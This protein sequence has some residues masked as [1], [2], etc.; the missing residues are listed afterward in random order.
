MF[1]LRLSVIVSS[2]ERLIEMVSLTF[3]RQTVSTLVCVCVFALI[4]AAPIV[5]KQTQ[6][7]KY[8]TQ[9]LPLG[10]EARTHTSKLQ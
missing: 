3:M 2:T 4:A 1:P 9:T 7:K 10:G 5:M 6:P 8:I